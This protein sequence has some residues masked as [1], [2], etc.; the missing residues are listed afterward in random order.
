MN[1]IQNLLIKQR[2]I[3]LSIYLL[4]NIYFTFVFIE[5]GILGGDFNYK[6]KANSEALFLGLVIILFSWFVLAFLFKRFSAIKVKPISFHNNRLLELFFLFLSLFYLYGCLQG[7][8]ISNTGTDIIPRPFIF[9]AANL[10]LHPDYLLIIY[11]FYRIKSPSLI[12]YI[13]L[14]STVLSYLLAGRSFIFI[15]L[16][17]LLNIY[18][19]LNKGK[20][21]LFWNFFL[22]IIGILIYPF[23]RFAKTMIPSYYQSEESDF[24]VYYI[25]QLFNGDIVETYINSFNSS[26]ERFQHVANMSFLIDK[27]QEIISYIS[28]FDYYSI[29]GGLS[30]YIFRVLF[31]KHNSIYLNSLF[32]SYIKGSLTSDW[33]VHSGMSGVFFVSPPL[34]LITISY[35]LIILFLT[36]MVTKL[37]DVH[38]SVNE[39]NWLCMLFYIFHGWNSAFLMHFE[40]L[41]IFLIVLSIFQSYS[42]KKVQ[43]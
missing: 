12:Y 30:A 26:L 2:R 16:L 42:Y 43:I 15:Y 21:Y 5:C 20:I 31:D 29:G 8:Y 40:S 14:I 17:P 22:I 13:T 25:F 19:I 6:F 1:Q 38:K 11:F 18:F 7:Y 23:I 3:L 28:N 4:S 24:M 27:Q 10:F 41:I 37:F 33:S 9:S 36:V 34:F 39:L 35:V 32:A